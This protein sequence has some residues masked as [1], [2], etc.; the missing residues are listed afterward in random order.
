MKENITLK[1]PL[2]LAD[3]NLSNISIRRPD[4]GDLLDCPVKDASDIKGEAVLLARLCGMNMEDFRK[5]DLEDYLQVQKSYLRFR[6]G[7]D[8]EE[9]SDASV[10]DS[11][12]AQG[13]GS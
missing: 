11:V 12:P 6:I 5:L 8:V 2:N 10:R 13:M 4:L 3:G 9:G 1:Y 7:N